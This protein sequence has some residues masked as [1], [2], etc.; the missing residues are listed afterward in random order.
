MQNGSN[1]GRSNPELAI[2]VSLRA[3]AIVKGIN[4]FIFLLS[5]YGLTEQNGLFSLKSATVRRKKILIQTRITPRYKLQCHTLPTA[6][7]LGK[8]TQFENV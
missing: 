3:Y 6:K 4:P 8:Y 5:I 7:E 2:Y 1:D